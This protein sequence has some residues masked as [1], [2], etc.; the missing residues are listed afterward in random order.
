MVSSVLK[1][2]I[3]A[4]SR[5]KCADCFSIL[6]PALAGWQQ[7][8]G[9]R[10]ALGR[11]SRFGNGSQGAS[12][13][14]PS[15]PKEE[16]AGERRPILAQPSQILRCAHRLERLRGGARTRDLLCCEKVFLVLLS[17][18]RQIW[19]FFPPSLATAAI[20]SAPETAQQGLRL[21][22][23]VIEPPNVFGIILR[24]EIASR[25]VVIMRIVPVKS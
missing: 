22:E 15:P 9:Y 3:T 23:R 2:G 24:H 14:Q 25:L 19:S 4:G 17:A 20:P 6:L 16:R 10:T 18:W 7:N 5:L 8:N 21:F 1:D 11:I 13:L 12:F